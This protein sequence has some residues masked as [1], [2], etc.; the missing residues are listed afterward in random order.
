MQLRNLSATI[1]KHPLRFGACAFLLITLI[2]FIN[3]R[4]GDISTSI[5]HW[6][7]FGDYI[8]GI[9]NPLFGLISLILIS[10]TL[11]NQTKAAKH[12]A[13]E[14][15]FFTL[16]QLY[17]SVLQNID[18]HTIIKNKGKN[19]ID[20]ENNHSEP[21][22]TQVTYIGRDCF[23]S[24][25]KKIQ[26]ISQTKQISMLDAYHFFLK[27]YG[28]EIEHYY[29]TVY[30]LF[31][32]VRDYSSDIDVSDVQRKRYYDLIKSQLSQYELVLLWLN[33]QSIYKGNWENIIR[34][35]NVNLFEHLNKANLIENP[36]QL[37]QSEIENLT[38]P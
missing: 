13:F 31:K 28:W 32:Y 21:Q 38:D 30:H 17:N 7:Q 11:K 27:D 14:S 19:L 3:F 37:T 29:R 24:F 33:T 1:I 26:Y 12:Q 8:G 23:R 20:S 5:D 16:L 2:F 4:K 36:P 18:Q 9:L 35:S 15:H 34:E 25:Y 22:S 10:E 6:G